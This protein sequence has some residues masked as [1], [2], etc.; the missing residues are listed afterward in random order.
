MEI[1][2]NGE[3]KELAIIDANGTY[4]EETILN[5]E[6]VLNFDWELQQY[7]MDAEDFEWWSEMA[8]KMNKIEEALTELSP[9][10]CDKLYS[11]AE[12]GNDL[13]DIIEGQLLFL[14]EIKEAEDLIDTEWGELSKE[15]QKKML[16]NAN[17]LDNIKEGDCTLDFNEYLSIAGHVK[18]ENG[19]SVISIDDNAV[20]YNPC[21]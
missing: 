14:K 16:S 1:L 4:C 2:V 10:Q 7:T 11:I 12:R 20:F 6:G 19:E 18:Q 15:Q 8:D 13:E 5:D 3:V 9:S 17:V 21:N